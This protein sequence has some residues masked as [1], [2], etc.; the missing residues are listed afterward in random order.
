MTDQP[1]AGQQAAP[2]SPGAASARASERGEGWERG[3]P[4]SLPPAAATRPA[5]SPPGG[6]DVWER[7]I[8]AGHVFILAVMVFSTL[9]A[10]AGGL[11]GAQLGLVLA[12]MG[13]LVAAYW[14][15]WIRRNL[16][17]QPAWLR[18]GHVVGL[19]VAFA[20]LVRLAPAFALLQFALYPQVFFALPQRWAIVGGLSIGAIMAS[21]TFVDRGGDFAAAA[22]EMVLEV[23]SAAAFT[24]VSAWI[25]AIIGQSA[26]RQALLQQLEETRADLAAAERLAGTL[27]ERERLSREIH[28]TLAQGFAS[29]VTHLEAADATLEAD[30]ARAREHLRAAEDVARASLDDTR[31]LVWALRPSSLADGG[32]P[33]ALERTAATTTAGGLAV[34]LTISGSSRPL[35]PEVEVSLLR[36]AQ[37][38]L[39]NARR[40]AGASRVALTLTY[41][42][43]EV[44]LDVIDD[45]RGFDPAALSAPGPAGGHGLFGMRERAE[46]LGGRLEVESTP[47]EGTVIALALP[48]IGPPVTVAVAS[49]S[50]APAP[51]PPAAP[52]SGGPA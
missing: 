27:E 29:V 45:G 31:G 17:E 42:D 22:P 51:A 43:D 21:D 47:G 28:D 16:W 6:V 44:A 13:A 32:L 8:P 5:E 2:G 11:A 39:T 37:E 25:G 1:G 19:L 14:L 20:A 9:S 49:G 40:H 12:I 48:A 50:P 15:V 24:M 4:P 46:R 34:D 7:W 52:A 38:G 23:V 26:E 30:A 3:A 35:H 36:A 41:F 10:V 33:A 18:A